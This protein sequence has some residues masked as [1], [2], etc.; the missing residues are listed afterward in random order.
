MAIFYER[1]ETKEKVTIR[2]KLLRLIFPLLM[3]VE[4]ITILLIKFAPLGLDKAT[5]FLW[6]LMSIGLFGITLLIYM[7]LYLIYAWNIENEMNQAKKEGRMKMSGSIL[8]FSNP[9]IV[10]ISKIKKEAGEK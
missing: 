2:Y 9:R 1:S 5:Q 8:S 6:E 7:P 10:E 3:I 4:T